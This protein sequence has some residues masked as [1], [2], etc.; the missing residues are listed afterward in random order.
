MTDTDTDSPDWARTR[1]AELEQEVERLRMALRVA[2]AV[3]AEGL[4]LS[5]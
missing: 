5:D 3:T 2:K 4:A 1:V